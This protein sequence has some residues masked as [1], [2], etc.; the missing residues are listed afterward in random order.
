MD[1]KLDIRKGPPG[2]DQ[3]VFLEGRLDAN[4]AGHLDDYLN[5]LV[6][7][8]SYRII[9][10]MGGVQY[11]SSMGIRIL[12]S[13]YKKIKKLGGLFVLEDLPEVVSDVLK[14]VGMFSLLTET[15]QEAAPL[16][17]V[18]AQFLEVN[19][20]RFDN[21]ILSGEKMTLNLTGNPE[22]S[23][24]SGFQSAD[25]QKIRF[26]A[27][28]YGLGIGAIGEGFEDC[29]SRYGEFIA[30]GDALAYK[31]SDGSKIPD[32]TVKAGKLEPEINALLSIQATGAFSNRVSFEP[33]EL[34]APISLENL[35]SGF[36]RSA[37]LEQFV[38][39]MIAESAGLVGVS[40]SV[41][42]VGG[43]KLFDFPGIRE[44][45]NFTTEP[46]YS[47]MLTLSVG[48]FSRNPGKD[49]KPFLRPVKPGSSDYIHTHAAVFPFQA[50]AK[51]ELSA[52][53][54]ITHLFD[55]SIVEDVIHLIHDSREIAGLGDSTF[56]QG[57]AW[58]GKFN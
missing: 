56:K 35:V 44:N 50:L 36:A 46:A 14:M 41:P 8:G 39:L 12:V 32:Y 42:P 33:M 3:R 11:L 18:T 6:R 17:K 22:L 16:E 57:V 53:K 45:I 34:A 15:A 38:F 5:G 25:N 23:L 19:Q 1:N 37:A 31:P 55:S 40:L 7:D 49:L 54:L 26:A 13:Q 29:R 47:R 20:Y 21:E 27:N 52:G 10:N 48:F 4:W 58:I 9:L 30:L 51:N 43:T 2:N 28:H 24:T